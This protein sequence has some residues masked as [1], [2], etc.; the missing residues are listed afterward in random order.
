MKL[1]SMELTRADRQ[2][3]AADSKPSADTG[4]VY[5]WGLS[6]N[7]DDETL[8]KLG[9]EGLPS[10]GDVLTIQA[11]VRVTGAN[12]NEREVD[13]EKEVCRSASLQITEMAIS[14]GKTADV[15]SALYDGNA[16][17]SYQ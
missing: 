8:Q 2:E 9:I 15:A 14:T 3:M 13:G 11:K 4:P 12:A 6:L 7:L 17:G 16:E 1:V 10:V 5:P